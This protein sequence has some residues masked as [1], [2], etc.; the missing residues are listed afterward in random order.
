MF[1]NRS[2]QYCTFEKKKNPREKLIIKEVMKETMILSI[3]YI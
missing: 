3:S 2:F 1:L